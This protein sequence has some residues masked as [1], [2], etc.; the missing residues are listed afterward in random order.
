M[1][2]EEL[3]LDDIPFQP[4]AE[5]GRYHAAAL[6]I[7]VGVQLSRDLVAEHPH[8]LDAEEPGRR[9]NTLLLPPELEAWVESAMYQPE[10]VS[11][12]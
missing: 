12:A 2:G 9:E 5:D 3:S 11:Y 8:Q 4:A 6:G 1:I 10:Y 7:F